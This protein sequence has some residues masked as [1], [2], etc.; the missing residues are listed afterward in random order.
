MSKSETIGSLSVGRHAYADG[1][2]RGIEGRFDPLG[3]LETIVATEDEKIGA[4]QGWRE[5]RAIRE[6]MESLKGVLEEKQ[7]NEVVVQAPTPS[8]D[9][10]P[11]WE[12]VDDDDDDFDYEARAD[13][14]VRQADLQRDLMAHQTEL[15]GRVQNRFDKMHALAE[16]IVRIEEDKETLRLRAIEEK[17]LSAYNPNKVT[18]TGIEELI[19]KSQA[20]NDT[21]HKNVPW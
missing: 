7:K 17:R 10:S 16:R 5:G 18:V 14:I 9:S 19:K 4:E 11:T 21:E 15:D 2:Q 13:L 12:I 1:L 20:E 6:Q 3:V 8:H